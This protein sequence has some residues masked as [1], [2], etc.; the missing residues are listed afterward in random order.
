M[1]AV[2]L[3]PAATLADYAGQAFVLSVSSAF[4]VA[5]LITFGP[6][7]RTTRNVA[8]VAGPLANLGVFGLLLHRS[9]PCTSECWDQAVAVA[10]AGFALLAWLVGAGVGY[11][12][13]SVFN[14][15]PSGSLRTRLWRLITLR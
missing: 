1:P 3:V 11:L 15:S 10:D 14:P 9:P 5:F 4:I 12:V 2:A 8:L 13:H 7:P 6:L